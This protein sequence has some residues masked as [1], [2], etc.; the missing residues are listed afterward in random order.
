MSRRQCPP[1]PA[2][3]RP[4]SSGRRLGFG[5]GRN[6]AARQRDNLRQAL[7]ENGCE[8]PSLGWGWGGSGY[9][10]LCVRTCDGYYFPISFSAG[11][12]RF[13][14]D[15]VVCKAMYGSATAELYVH[16]NNSPAGAGGL[17]D[18]KAARFRTVCLPVPPELQ[19]ELSGRTDVRHNQAWFDLLSL[20]RPRRSGAEVGAEAE[21][22]RSR[23]GRSNRAERGP[24]DAR[25]HGRRLPHR[26]GGAAGGS[27]RRQQWPMPPPT[28][29]G[30]ARTT[31]MSN[32]SGST[33]SGRSRP[34]RPASTSS[35][36]P[37]PRSP[38]TNPIRT[39]PTVE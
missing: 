2:A 18:R 6:Q 31:I 30:S 38:S 36:P 27:R 23:A 26:A 29:A 8:I 12:Q 25:Q 16:S 34:A 22:P 10:T 24:R 14:T 19:L 39:T 32:R 20:A 17:V 35:D 7:I 9:R 3:A 4:Q 37:T 33:R 13:K 21:A 1:Q 15:E 28:F 5:F 11:R